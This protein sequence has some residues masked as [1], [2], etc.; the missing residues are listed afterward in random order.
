MASIRRK[1]TRWCMMPYAYGDMMHLL[2][3]YDVA[4]VGRNDAMFAPMCRQAHIIREANIIGEAN[5]I[6][7]RQ[8][9]FK[10]RTFVGRQKRFLFWQRMRD[11]ICISAPPGRNQCSH[12]F[13]NWWQQ[14]STGQLHLDGFE[15]ISKQKRDT[16]KGVSLFWWGRTDSNHRSDTQQIYSLSPLATRELPHIQLLFVGAGRRTRTPDLLITNQLLYRLSYTGGSNRTR[17][18]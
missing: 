12:Q 9:S 1:D 18:L 2:R 15:S 4:P 7:R 5:I 14:L 11:S 10:K 6:C 8:T 13:L 3:K 16:P 17:L